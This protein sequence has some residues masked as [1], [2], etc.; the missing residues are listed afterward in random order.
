MPTQVSLVQEYSKEAG[1]LDR[2]TI[3]QRYS[4][5]LAAK[6]PDEIPLDF[7]QYPKITIGGISVYG[8]PGV[9]RMDW[10]NHQSGII[11][12]W[13]HAK[14]NDFSSVGQGRIVSRGNYHDINISNVRNPDDLRFLKQRILTL[15]LKAYLMKQCAAKE[16][17]TEPFYT[18]HFD[19]RHIR[20]MLYYR[21]LVEHFLEIEK[22]LKFG[23]KK[24]FEKLQHSQR[25]LQ[26]GASAGDL[27]TNLDVRAHKKELRV[28]IEPGPVPQL[29]VTEVCGFNQFT[30]QGMVVAEE[31]LE[32]LIRLETTLSLPP[33]IARHC[34][35][36][37]DHFSISAF[38]SGSAA[39]CRAAYFDLSDRKTTYLIFFKRH[40]A[41]I[42]VAVLLS[43]VA[44]CLF[45]GVPVFAPL[46]LGA[47]TMAPSIVLALAPVLL[48]AIAYSAMTRHYFRLPI[49][50]VE[51]KPVMDWPE[52]AA[53]E[54]SKSPS[55][56]MLQKEAETHSTR[57]PSW[58]GLRL[59][60]RKLE[61]STHQQTKPN[62]LKLPLK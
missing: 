18:N 53:A 54:R 19:L 50:S 32:D 49:T 17:P 55:D 51:L 43:V 59:F 10:T 44:A 27:E 35:V 7:F 60:S 47:L 14:I 26:N 3:P 45:F 12:Q 37:L 33:P 31:N 8:E 57:N 30:E 23:Y 34:V 1:T 36:H 62:L 24:L 56:A 22:S 15:I 28:D 58:W 13:L 9:L 25:G 4:F 20:Y 61:H 21:P 11:R 48:I 40:K 41:L 29:K 16:A 6:S 2:T 42:V 46:V 38:E 5:Q 39:R 52:H